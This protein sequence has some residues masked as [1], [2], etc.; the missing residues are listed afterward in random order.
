M[1]RFTLAFAWI[2]LLVCAPVGVPE[3]GWPDSG[4]PEE[5]SG[6]AGAV[7]AEE[8]VVTATRV[9]ERTLDVPQHVDVITSEEIER[10]AA[11][12]VAE[13]LERRSGVSVDDYGPQGAVQN[14]TIRGSTSSQVIV[15][16]DGV[17]LNNAQ[18]GGVD[19]SVVPLDSVERIEVARGG[20]S[21]VYGAD[22]I[23]GVVNIIT[24]KD[25]ANRLRLAFENGSFIPKSHVTGYTSDKVENPPDSGDLLDTQRVTAQFSRDLGGSALNLAGSF[26]L[27]NNGYVFKDTNNEDRKRQNAG[28]LGGDLSAGLHLPAGTGRLGII[29]SVFVNEKGVPGPSTSPTLDASQADR[30]LQTV[31]SYDT[32]DFL[33]RSLSFDVK[34]HYTYQDLKYDH[35]PSLSTHAIHSG[36]IDLTHELFTTGALSFIYGGNVNYDQLNSSD[37]GSEARIY[38]GLFAEV[39]L[40]LSA[41]ATLQPA[42]RYD[43]YTDF[44]GSLNYKLGFVYRL[45]DRDSFKT[46]VSKSFR[47]P[48]FNDLYWPADEFAEG[49][50]DLQPETAYELDVGYT[51][52]SD[53]VMLDFF[54]F[55][56]YSSDVILWQPGM[57]G[58]WRPS[59]YGDALYPGVEVSAEWNFAKN[60]TGRVDYTYLY[61]FVLSG[62]FTMGDNKRLPMIPVHEFEASVVFDDGK[63]TLSAGLRFESL[64]YE[65]T[66]NDTYLPSHT[67]VDALYRRR[68]GETWSLYIAADNLFNES[69]EVV[70]GYPMPGT[71]IRSGVELEL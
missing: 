21:A 71:F 14:V 48:T 35:P 36:G 49:N 15:L 27:A 3:S 55:I 17:R 56:R 50:P 62:G 23:G 46:S 33:S 2:G 6:S 8:V 19:L 44:G 65:R 60:V 18:S 43:Y 39:P 9:E 26:I 70:N 67:V 29:G 16:L 34:G 24:K 5:D 37:V 45:S 28:L 54:G 38:T 57:D 66:S 41:R 10:S 30:R 51:R 7:A 61:T 40:Y 31:V 1:K 12:D 42:V 69:Y 13:L 4:A 25:A 63:N 68:F 47:A 22:A 58:I 59:N 20:T 11:R 64:R 32:D 52:R 53:A